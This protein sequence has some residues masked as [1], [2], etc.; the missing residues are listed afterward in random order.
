[1]ATPFTDTAPG[2]AHSIRPCWSC[3]GPAAGDAAF[4][5]TCGVI[6][7]PGQEDHFARLGLERRFDLD[8]GTIDRAYFARQRQVHPDRFARRA[9]REAAIA[10][11]R[12]VSLNAAYQTL[13]DPL[14][15]ATYLLELAGHPI[16]GDGKTI[17]DPELL[18]EV[19]ERREALAEADSPEA[20]AAVAA[21]ARHERVSAEAA[22]G[23]A[24]AAGDYPAARRHATRLRYLGRLA[25]EARRRSAMR[26]A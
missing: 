10:E 23:A 16:A 17:A 2:G 25:E 22:L 5:E 6:Q 26:A 15:R 19:M 14:R 7:P 11:S 20:V 12:S 24:F 1:M 13:R 18:A 9:P 3:R 4:C 8:A 21:D